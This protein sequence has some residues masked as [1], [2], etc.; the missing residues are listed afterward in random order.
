MI[1]CLE[2][3]GREKRKEVIVRNDYN[4]DDQYNVTHRDAL[5]TGDAQGKGT[6]H[7]GHSHW[8]PDC[9]GTIG[10]I[11]YSNFDTHISSGAGNNTDNYQ[12]KVS[13][14]RSLYTP[15]NQ[16]SEGMIDTSANVR[17]GQYVNY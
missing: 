2:T 6:G 17:E 7:A 10:V 5:A 1:S 11:N 9:S 3:T 8:L 16:Y 15:D 12:R 13:M 14:V 4:R